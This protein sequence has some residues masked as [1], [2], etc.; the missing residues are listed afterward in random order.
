MC[1]WWLAS[2]CLVITDTKAAVWFNKEV[3]TSN[4]AYIPGCYTGTTSIDH[5][6]KETVRLIRSKYIITDEKKKRTCKRTIYKF[7]LAGWL[8]V[9][10]SP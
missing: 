1:G 3:Y 8:G 5:R 2:N 7:T 9:Y 6:P 10:E 4:L